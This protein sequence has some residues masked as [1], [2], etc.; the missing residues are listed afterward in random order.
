M[1]IGFHT[2]G[3]ADSDECLSTLQMLWKCPILEDIDLDTLEQCILSHDYPYFVALL[4]PFVKHEKRS[5]LIQVLTFIHYQFHVHPSIQ[6]SIIEFFSFS[7][8]KIRDM[9]ETCD[10]KK[11]LDEKCQAYPYLKQIT[12]FMNNH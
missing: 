7:L 6:L 3:N 5:S 2:S 4:L 9:N 8:Q 1:E 10:L 12:K 11:H